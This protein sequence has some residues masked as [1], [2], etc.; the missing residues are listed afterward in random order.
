MADIRIRKR[1]RMRSKEIKALSSE[2]EEMLGVPVFAEDDTVDIAES[3]DF[4]LLFVDNDILGLIVEG[5]PFL[6]IRGII[7]YRPAKRYVT[8]DMGAVPFITNGADCMG[9]GIVEADPSI[10]VGDLV[11]IR[12]EK[13]K[14]PLAIGIS[15]RAGEEL[16][17]KSPGK[18]IRN[19]HNVGDKL[20]KT[21]E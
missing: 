14:V 1:K 20:W 19:V 8:V 2:L 4:D 10:S 15:E 12:D 16:I 13:N 21:G 9:P 3:S 5:K 11:W 18:A 17:R 6:T 7:K